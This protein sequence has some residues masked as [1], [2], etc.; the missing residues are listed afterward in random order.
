MTRPLIAALAGLLLPLLPL[1]AAATAEGAA[2]AEAAAEPV[3]VQFRDLFDGNGKPTARAVELTGQRVVIEGF[4]SP[5]PT[6]ASPFL[7]FVGAPTQHCPYC[8]SVNDTAHLPYI[9]VYPKEG[10]D[11]PGFVRRRLRVTGTLEAS[12]DHEPFYGLH[13]D[14]RI[15][16][17]LVGPAD[18]GR[19]HLREPAPSLLERRREIV[20]TGEDE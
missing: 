17:A 3:R 4:L 5:S 7:V 20:E 13:N 11:P 14:I 10:T 2:A 6:R 12:H 9:L 15:R 19:R 16:T 1:E 8:T 18:A